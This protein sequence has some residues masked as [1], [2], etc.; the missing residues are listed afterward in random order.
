MAIT[1]YQRNIWPEIVAEQHPRY[2]ALSD[3]TISLEIEEG[4]AADSLEKDPLLHQVLIDN[5]N[6][7]VNNKTSRLLANY[8]YRHETNVMMGI[9]NRNFDGIT[10]EYRRFDEFVRYLLAVTND[11]LKHLIRTT[12]E[13]QAKDKTAVT[14]YK[15]KTVL[16]LGFKIVGITWSVGSLIVGTGLAI[17][18][19]G[20]LLAIPGLTWGLITSIQSIAEL[21]REI[22]KAAES[23]KTAGLGALSSLYELERKYKGAGATKIGVTEVVS[24]GINKVFSGFVELNTITTLSDKFELWGNKILVVDQKTHGLA[25]KL[26]ELFSKMEAIQRAIMISQRPPVPSRDGCKL[27]VP[28]PIPSREGRPSRHPLRPKPPEIPSRAGR[29]PG[30]VVREMLGMKTPPPVPSRL[31]RPPAPPRSELPQFARASHRSERDTTTAIGRK[32]TQLRG[33]VN[34]T[35]SKTIDLQS[36]VKKQKFLEERYKGALKNLKGRK[37]TAASFVETMA[38]ATLGITKAG[39][40]LGL[41]GFDL[42][43]GMT[44]AFDTVHSLVQFIADETLDAVDLSVDLTES[45]GDMG[46]ALRE[47]GRR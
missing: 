47:K 17:A 20:P 13:S 19:G 21:G 42:S 33:K 5:I 12:I 10:I 41:S 3:F 34:T 43:Q 16:K 1:I 6:E 44:T 45:M 26:P 32:L 36:E 15:T 25:K 31:G 4:A 35:I 2:M 11:N 24:G 28:P 8:V 46:K 39:I 30:I 9:N 14:L 18:A 22:F 23:L 38:N 40:G 7:F 37:T 29:V 27:R